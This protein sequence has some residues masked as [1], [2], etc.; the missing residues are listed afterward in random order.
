MR[1]DQSSPIGLLAATGFA[2]AGDDASA[3][4]ILAAVKTRARSQFVCPYEIASVHAALGDS[5]QAFAWL[6]RARTVRSDCMLWL[7]IEPWFDPLRRDSRFPEL[8]REVTFQ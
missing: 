7:T 5:D 1:L 4:R 8:A 3:R 6:E 2:R